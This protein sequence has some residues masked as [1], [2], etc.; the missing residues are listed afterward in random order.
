[1]GGV[2]KRARAFRFGS[3]SARVLLNA[4]E[5]PFKLAGISQ[6]SLVRYRFPIAGGLGQSAARAAVARPNAYAH[7]R[8]AKATMA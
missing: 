8:L 6:L 4:R 5:W 3:T 7:K 1:M 2:L